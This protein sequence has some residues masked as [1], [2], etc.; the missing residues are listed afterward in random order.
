[1]RPKD[2]FCCLSISVVGRGDLAGLV[3][4][5]VGLGDGFENPHFDR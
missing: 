3:V 1:M 5:E 2:N 4:R